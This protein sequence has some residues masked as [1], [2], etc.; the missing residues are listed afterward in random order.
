MATAGAVALLT[1]GCAERSDFDPNNRG[2]DTETPQTSVD[3][4]FIVP[5]YQPGRCAIQ[6]GS[7]ANLRFSATNSRPAES[8]RLLAITT[9]AADAVR[10]SASGEMDIAPKSSQQF[11]ATVEGLRDSVRPAM[12]VDVTFQFAKS[13]EIELRVPVEACPAQTT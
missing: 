2:S 1:A 6:V 4:A 13:G 9:D 3:N 8:E 5:A 11:I 7:A 12:S 10:I